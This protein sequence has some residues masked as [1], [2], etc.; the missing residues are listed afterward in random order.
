M[1]SAIMILPDIVIRVKPL[2]RGHSELLPRPTVL[3]RRVFE[4]GDRMPLFDSLAWD[5]EHTP[6]EHLDPIC[7]RLWR[8]Y[9]NGELTDD[10]AQSLA[11]LARDRQHPKAPK[12]LPPPRQ[13]RR[14]PR[15]PDRQR[16]LERRRR[17]SAAGMM[18]P[19][20]A[21]QFTVGERAVLYV[22]ARQVQQRGQ[23]DLY[24]DQ[25]AA[26]AAVSRTTARN[27]M[28]M[29]KRL[30]LIQIDERRLSRRYNDAN[31]VTI[32]SKEWLAWL[33]H[34]QKE[35]VKNVKPTY[36]PIFKHR[37]A[38]AR[39]KPENLV[40]PDSNTVRGASG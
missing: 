22:V 5:I 30:E 20:L 26:F 4:N 21:A 39:T 16:S 24:I 34:G 12:P 7:S 1:I 38:R 28:R 35:T 36:Q 13:A 27:A 32:V 18:P 25:I 19:G 11:E 9:A 8:A 6:L 37:P 14:P 3:A 40:R 10:E 33:A 17:L 29:A 23:C 31:K 2:L 15:S